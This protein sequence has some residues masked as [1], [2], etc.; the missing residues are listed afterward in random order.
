MLFSFFEGNSADK[1]L[2]IDNKESNFGKLVINLLKKS[3]DKL[4]IRD[5]SALGEI[6]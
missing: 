3:S 5:R 6:T 1:G 2:G 4:E